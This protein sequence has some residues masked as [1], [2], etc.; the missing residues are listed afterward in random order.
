MIWRSTLRFA[1]KVSV[2]RIVSTQT[3]FL[4]SRDVFGPYYNVDYPIAKNLQA[5]KFVEGFAPLTSERYSRILKLASRSK[6]Q[7]EACKQSVRQN[8]GG[9]S[10]D[11]VFPFAELN[12]PWLHGETTDHAST[13]RD[14]Y[15]ELGQI[16]VSTLAN[17]WSQFQ[18]VELA[19]EEPGPSKNIEFVLFLIGKLAGAS[20]IHSSGFVDVGYYVMHYMDSGLPVPSAFQKALELYAYNTEVD[21]LYSR[22][23]EAMSFLESKAANYTNVGNAVKTLTECMNGARSV[24]SGDLKI[25]RHIETP[26]VAQKIPMSGF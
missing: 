1:D 8:F 5:P 21:V 14:V 25:S 12:L 16:G 7:Q 19:G 23:R 11:R 15:P 18:N 20:T 6:L 26:F 13:L 2:L 3:I 24:S 22:A 4:K 17:L 9:W 10:P